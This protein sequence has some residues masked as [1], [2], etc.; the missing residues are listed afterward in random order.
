MGGYSS[1][2]WGAAMRAEA[3]DAPSGR[4]REEALRFVGVPLDGVRS[5][6]AWTRDLRGAAFF[7]FFISI[8]LGLERSRVQRAQRGAAEQ[9][10][11]Q[12]V[13]LLA[14]VGIA[15]QDEPIAALGDAVLARQ[16]AGDDHHV[17]EQRFI[18]VGDIVRGRN[19]LVRHDED[20]YRG[21]G[22]DVQECDDP[23]IAEDD[24]GG[25]LPRYDF[26]EKR[27]HVER[28]RAVAARLAGSCAM[29]HCT[30]KRRMGCP[31]VP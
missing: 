8:I 12:V 7:F 3:D 14:A 25:Q 24:V 4:G 18:L 29:P 5:A 6:R 30:I 13:D 11:M 10:E 22:S 9:M 2:R 26:L 23:R 1:R 16:V 27:R 28:S 20:M 19:W 21:G 15:V 31:L 17:S